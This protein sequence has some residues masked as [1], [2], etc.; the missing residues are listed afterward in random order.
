MSVSLALQFESNL[1]FYLNAYS[2]LKKF[3]FIFKKQYLI[4][5]FFLC[6]WRQT[7]C[8]TCIKFYEHVPVR[9]STFTKVRQVLN[10]SQVLKDQIFN[11]FSLGTSKKSLLYLYK[12]I[13][14]TQS[15]KGSRV[16]KKLNEWIVATVGKFTTA[17][18][19]YMTNQ[20]KGN[21]K[22]EGL[23]CILYENNP[24][25]YILMVILEFT[26]SSICI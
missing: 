19:V 15:L 1:K 22:C 4:L 8:L 17:T 10:I 6:Y 3:F 12:R 9:I 11:F 7:L 21:Q 20:D 13:Q 23:L 24:S 25:L 14:I 16:L 5:Y 2:A 18:M 26:L